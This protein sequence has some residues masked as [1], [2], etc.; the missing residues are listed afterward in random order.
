MSVEDTDEYHIPA[1]QWGARLLQAAA[2]AHNASEDNARSRRSE[3]AQ[4]ESS[5]RDGKHILRASTESQST[6]VF[7]AAT[8]A[9]PNSHMLVASVGATL[10]LLHSES[11]SQKH[12][13]ELGQFSRILCTAPRE[14]EALVLA[15]HDDGG[16]SL[17]RVVHTHC[18]ADPKLL[19]VASVSPLTAASVS[20]TSSL[21]VAALPMN[22]AEAGDCLVA[23]SAGS[24]NLLQCDCNEQPNG[25]STANDADDVRAVIEIAHV[26]S[27]LAA[28][29]RA[30]ASDTASES[31]PEV[32]HAQL[33]SGERSGYD[34]HGHLL[35][36]F[37][38]GASSDSLSWDGHCSLHCF[39]LDVHRGTAV[40]PVF[41]ITL[42]S[43]LAHT[44][45]SFP[46]S[47]PATLCVIGDDQVCV[48]RD[49]R[50]HH[51]IINCCEAS[52]TESL[53]FTAAARKDEFQV[54]LASCDTA[55]NKDALVALDINNQDGSTLQTP[56]DLMEIPLRGCSLLC[57]VNDEN[58]LAASP[59]GN[60]T[61]INLCS[62]QESH[63]FAHDDWHAPLYTA[64]ASL[65]YDCD[66]LSALLSS[67]CKCSHA[68]CIHNLH[69]N[70]L[71]RTS[72]G[73]RLY[74]SS[75]SDLL[76]V[77]P[78]DLHAITISRG[79]TM[80]AATYEA[81]W[82]TCLWSID[83]NGCN[84]HG[85]DTAQQ[86]NAYIGSE[87]T[88]LLQAFD[89]SSNA[90]IHVAPSSAEVRSV[91]DG[92]ALFEHNHRIL[93]SSVDQRFFHASQSGKTLVLATRTR[94]IWCTISAD[95][96]IEAAHSDDTSSEIAGI[97]AFESS[98]GT[99]HA[100]LSLWGNCCIQITKR[101]IVLHEFE[102]HMAQPKKIE[103]LSVGGTLTLAIG[104][105]R[106]E[107]SVWLVELQSETAEVSTVLVDGCTLG[108]PHPSMKQA[109]WRR[110]DGS[111]CA[112]ILCC[113]DTSAYIQYNAADA[114]PQIVPIVDAE[115][116]HCF[117]FVSQLKQAGLEAYPIA[118]ISSAMSLKFGSLHTNVARRSRS[119]ELS[120][121][122]SDV[123]SMCLHEPSGCIIALVTD[124]ASQGQTK[125][126][127]HH[128]LSLECLHS[129]PY[130]GQ[131]ID[132]Y[133]TTCVIIDRMGIKREVT[134]VSSTECGDTYEGV[135]VC[136]GRSS[137]SAFDVLHKR[138]NASDQKDEIELKHL[139]S[140][141][142]PAAIHSATMIQHEQN[143]SMFLIGC[144]DGIRLIR[145]KL[146]YE[147]MSQ[148]TSL[149]STIEHSDYN[150]DAAVW[151][152]EGN[153]SLAS[154][155]HI[156][157]I[158]SSGPGLQ[159]DIIWLL[160]TPTKGCVMSVGLVSREFAIA[161]ELLGP[162]QILHFAVSIY[163]KPELCTASHHVDQLAPIQAMTVLPSLRAVMISVHP[164][165]LALV[166]IS[167]ALG[168]HGLECRV[169]ALHMGFL[170]IVLLE[171]RLSG[172]N[173]SGKSIA[174]VTAIGSAGEV[175]TVEVIQQEHC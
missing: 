3:D 56:S 108:G 36:A 124:V 39:S 58:V 87:P 7:D 10:M 122:E 130:A 14:P 135:A 82:C 155:K 119:M 93:P 80:I 50:G 90:I 99:S 13:T 103:C 27:T 74:H 83:A 111:P 128:A 54:L 120:N 129:V 168:N 41:T 140:H 52:A 68:C 132:A 24:L 106:G 60:S 16:A 62:Q 12:A 96:G 89:K 136:S 73:G 172:I 160:H 4:Y 97:S 171:S 104:A 44:L 148:Q 6:V 144:G 79:I 153:D 91:H 169:D 25:E 147:L 34:V 57:M 150:N 121:S 45:V 17:V 105:D 146:D 137:L 61:L 164:S 2:F 161:V 134:L 156:R 26:H 158:I 115:G 84:L 127:V 116:M 152:S 112:G 174:D 107:I 139:G 5:T 11:L 100:V 33:I 51:E 49:Q 37:L 66:R 117:E 92:A 1:A 70:H 138:A 123:L 63:L 113:A 31:S 72:I 28:H 98:G 20:Q 149:G 95:Y 29:R 32:L 22:G 133:V 67:T 102:T 19:I 162:I 131:I 78:F 8:L 76:D 94:L 15:V 143:S 46:L 175:Q 18:S 65:N 151:T 81:A 101:G 59:H 38:L 55:N 145:I 47:S 141:A 154:D 166:R 9:Q 75:T 35:V 114:R 86:W 165:T 109:V 40:S 30:E 157:S 163:Q 21:A 126:Q 85:N 170:P 23:T 71:Q 118:W 142:L 77:V 64:V 69:S 42:L 159:V 110:H 167:E 125:L 173:G 48:V 43:P 88:V 53:C